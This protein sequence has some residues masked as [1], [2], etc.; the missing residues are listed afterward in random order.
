MGMSTLVRNL[1]LVA[2]LSFLT[3]TLAAQENKIDAP[4]VV[5]I[6]PSLTTSGQPTA[7][8]L[9][10]LKEQAYEA[11]IYLAPPTVSDAVKEESVLLAKQGIEFIN[12]PIV[13]SSPS[14]A[15]FQEF[16]RHMQRLGQRKILVHCQI[17]MRA[18][19]M[20]FLYR[21]IILKDAP[22]KA[23]ESVIRVWSPQGA[24][25]ELITAQL[26]KHEIEFKPY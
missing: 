23:Y 3:S 14:E 25:R 19:S 6:S 8:A 9:A 5:A 1:A 10:H 7:Q 12:I 11:V 13:F 16:V 2:G 4:N 24:W 22:D 18:S 15:D 21:S 26:R 17:N 20:V